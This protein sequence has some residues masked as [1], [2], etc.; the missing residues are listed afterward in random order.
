MTIKEIHDLFNLLADKEAGAYFPPGDIDKFLDRGQIWLFNEYLPLYAESAEIDAALT[1]FKDK[2]D[3]STNSSG[4]YTIASNRNYVRLR[5][6]NVSVVHS[7]YGTQR[8]DV[9]IMKD[10]ELA[11]RLKS[12]LLAP[13]ASNP[14]GEEVGT[15][16]FIIYPAATHAGT[17]RFFRRPAAPVFGYTQ[18][19]RVITYNSGTST[20][21]EWTEPYQN[22]VVLRALHLAGINLNDQ[23]LQQAGIMLPEK[24]V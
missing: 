15:G 7:T 13:S 1:P 16:S 17:I 22:K 23:Q 9:K 19:G 6:I 24:D 20:Q 12:Q 14:V 2:V 21:L 5:S 10:D 11:N 3:Y 4:A 8:H 18:V